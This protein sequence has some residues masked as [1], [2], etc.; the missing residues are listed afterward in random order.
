MWY[1]HNGTLYG[2]NKQQRTT[3]MLI[4][5]EPQKHYGKLKKP[6]NRDHT[7][8]DFVYMKCPEIW[9]QKGDEC[10]LEAQSRNRV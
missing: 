1:S 8:P 3:N 2:D 6:D 5:S 7:E 10:L 4:M 9:R